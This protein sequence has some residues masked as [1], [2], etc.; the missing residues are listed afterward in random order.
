MLNIKIIAPVAMLFLLAGTAMADSSPAT[1]VRA[2]AVA[3]ACP[4][5]GSDKNPKCYVCAAPGCPSCHN[6]RTK[7]TVAA[8]KE[9]ALNCPSAVNPHQ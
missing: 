2:K 8:S 7:E 5:G 1:M 6:E 9:A 4:A 3:E